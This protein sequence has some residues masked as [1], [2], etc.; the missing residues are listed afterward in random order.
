M[1][2]ITSKWKTICTVGYDPTL[3]VE[4]TDGSA[5]R[6][7]GGVCLCQARMSARSG[8]RGRKVNTT[9]WPNREIGH[10]F[11]LERETLA[12]WEAIASGQK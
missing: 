8:L 2:T 10:T 12:H 9:G 4:R 6:A 11:A 1:T 3:P 7:R 5:I